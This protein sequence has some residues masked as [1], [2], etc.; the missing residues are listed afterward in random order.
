MEALLQF[1]SFKKSS[2]RFKWAMWLNSEIVAQRPKVIGFDNLEKIPKNINPVI[3][4]TH[5]RTDASLQIIARELCRKFNLGIAVQSGNRKVPIIN[6]LFTLIGQDN[7][8][9]I[10]SVTERKKVY[11]KMERV[12]KYKINLSNYEVMKDAMEKGKTILISAHY[13]PIYTGVLPKKPGFAMIYLAH[14]SGQR[15]VVP[16]VLD[17]HTD[18][19][20]IGRIDRKF[21]I[22]KN[23]LMGNRPKSK[24]TICEPI[25]LDSIDPS[26]IELMKKWIMARSDRKPS[27]L[28]L[29]EQEKAAEAYRR[30]RQVDGSKVMY[31]IAQALPLEKRGIWSRK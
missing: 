24:M 10:D 27:G 18:D 21:N 1:D 6:A 17:M 2:R 8:Y 31:A 25:T 23:L 4:A 19:E 15:V 5:L 14:L 30:M 11:G 13:S 3:A 28:N 22:V 9:D 16:V 12:D 20:G 29:K 7:F 26:S